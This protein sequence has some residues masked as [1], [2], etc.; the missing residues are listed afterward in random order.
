MSDRGTRVEDVG[1]S[2]EELPSSECAAPPVE[3]AGTVWVAQAAGFAYRTLR[4][5]SRSWTVLGVAIGLPP[6]M[7]LLVTATR[8][9]DP[10]TKGLFAVGIAALG[11][12]IASLTVFGSQLAVDLEADRFR[13][14]RSMAVS[15]S[16]DLAG[17]MAAS[18]TVAALAL[19]FGL[20]VGILDGAPLGVGS[21]VQAATVVAALLGLSVVLM[22]AA[23]PIVVA[24]NNEQYAQ[25][26][27]S[28]VAVFG[29]MLTGYNGMLP[30]VAILDQ[31]VV[32]LFP[33][34]LATRAMAVRLVTVE[35]VSAIDFV[36]TAGRLATLAV[37]SA[38]TAAVGT[39]L[40]RWQLY[41][42]EVLR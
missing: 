15:P 36:G 31:S 2:S 25:F 21:V 32:Q 4:D 9:F 8:S 42:K 11:A 17:R 10:T 37:Y 22:T 7:Y 34:V 39:A 13:A 16:A 24:A 1:A 12:M 23:I 41:D 19:I 20:A 28:L 40:A 18:S 27:L 3:R 14:Y 6:M 35:G 26:A 38:G 30:S 5:V 33:N 29:F